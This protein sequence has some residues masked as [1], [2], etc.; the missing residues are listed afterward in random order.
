MGRRV[1]IPAGAKL[2]ALPAGSILAIP[3]PNT[4]GH[5]VA[6]EYMPNGHDQPHA[7]LRGLVRRDDP[8]NAR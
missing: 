4:P 3:P 1:S 7:S 2:T 8:V 6:V 5:P